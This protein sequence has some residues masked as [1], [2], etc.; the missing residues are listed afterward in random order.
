MH[1]EYH[2]CIFDIII[3]FM[4]S[5]KEKLLGEKIKAGLQQLK[6]GKAVPIKKA[7]KRLVK[8]YGLP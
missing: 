7:M 3:S 2:F 8:K 6:E 1:K 4:S 5:K